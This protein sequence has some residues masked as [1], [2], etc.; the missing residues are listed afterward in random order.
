MR[1]GMIATLGIMG[2]AA[3]GLWMLESQ[4][5]HRPKK[6][7]VDVTND[8]VAELR[9]QL[10]SLQRRLALDEESTV[11]LS[12]SVERE[13]V[14]P[15]TQASKS[16]SD[17]PK[18][19]SAPPTIEQQTQLFKAHFSNLDVLRG[20]VPDRALEAKVRDVFRRGGEGDVGRL[21]EAKID[22]VACGNQFCRVEVV[23]PDSG[24]VRLA[25]SQVQIQLA[26][27]AN[28]MTIFSEPGSTRLLAYV[29][30]GQRQL[31]DFPR[32]DNEPVGG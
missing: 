19:P 1:I 30:T 26:T 7:H 32:L 4:H 24:S 2:L 20:T 21:N 11:A 14:L 10:G 12:R 22:V 13:T 16:E 29:A 25:Q 23:L 8:G 6:Q 5:A 9:E 31:P 18:T 3:G 17:Q 27:V 28:Q 15:A